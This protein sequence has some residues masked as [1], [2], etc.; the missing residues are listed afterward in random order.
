MIRRMTFGV[1]CLA[2]S[3]AALAQPVW[4]LDVRSPSVLVTLTP[5]R[6]GSL[7]HVVVAYGTVE[8]SNTGG[9]AMMAGESG[10]IG[11]VYVRI[12]QRVAAGA[13]LVQILPSPQSAAAY[14]QARS[15]LKVARALVRS[16]RKLYSLH[17]AT[18]E[19]LAAAERSQ[20]D[21]QANLAALRAAGAGGPQVLRAPFASVITTLTALTG[22]IVSMG[23]PVLTLASP[24]HLVLAAGV[25]P[26]QALS[27]AVGDSAVVQATGSDEWVH[28]HVAMSGAASTPNTGLV[29][30]QI[31]LP[32]GEFIPGQVARARITT[33]EVKG[34][35]VP[36]AA[37][38]VNER[39]APYVVQ[40]VEGIAHKVPVRVLDEYDDQDI[41]SGALDP[42]AAVVL[43]GDYQLDNG[44]HIRIAKPGEPGTTP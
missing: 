15:S 25:V 16:T 29:P 6:S 1:F 38:L 41:I 17:L 8:P 31:A 11:T 35:L 37:L 42:R 24:D 43:A 19:Q 5:L 32:A 13:P 12:G 21:A 34:F 33:A 36:H 23:S 10:V 44:M 18:N 7:P 2:L 27:M 20:L 22:T 26:S 3:A 40:A 14:H 4:A 9:R 39:G 30:V 28:A